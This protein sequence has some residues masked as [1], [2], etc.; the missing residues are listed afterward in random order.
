MESDIDR[1]RDAEQQLVAVEAERGELADRLAVLRLVAKA[2]G[3]DGVPLRIVEGIA[4][5]RLVETANR[6]LDGLGGGFR[7]EVRTRRQTARGE[8]RDALDIMVWQDGDD[9]AYEELSGGE[10]TRVDLALRL[11]LSELLAHRRGA[12]IGVLV[13]DEPDWLDAA[14]LEQLATVLQGDLGFRR[15]LVISHAPGLADAFDRVVR[16]QRAADGP[17]LA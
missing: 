15:T 16:V 1:A 8:E 3:R 12:D 2:S 5:P 4:V 7:V 13:I 6:V 11:G 9:A 10:R 14:G 17:V